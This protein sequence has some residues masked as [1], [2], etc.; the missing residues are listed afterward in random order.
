MSTLKKPWAA[1]LKNFNWADLAAMGRCYA[2]AYTAATNQLLPWTSIQDNFAA[3]LPRLE[4]SA[5]GQDAADRY[6][7]E[8][9]E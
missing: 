4:P 6:I 1:G 2:R 7:W 5:W 3:F 9:D 8:R